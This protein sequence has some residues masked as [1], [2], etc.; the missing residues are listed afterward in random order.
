[1]KTYRVLAETSYLVECFIKA[2]SQEKAEELARDLDG[3]DF[4]EIELSGDWT[5]I[6]V[7]E[8]NDD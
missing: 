1:M 3:G 7:E 6:H 5:L 2:E 4:T 8:A